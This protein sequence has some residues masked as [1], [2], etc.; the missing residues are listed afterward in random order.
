MIRERLLHQLPLGL[1]MVA[2]L[3]G[4]IAIGMVLDGSLF[5][6]TNAS[7][8]ATGEAEVRIAVTPREDGSIKVG[9]QQQGDDGTWDKVRYPDLN[10]VPAGAEPNRRLHSSVLTVSTS[11]DVYTLADSYYDYARG[12]AAQ[13]ADFSPD[14]QAW[15]LL[16]DA[17]EN[18]PGR[19]ICQG[20]AD[21]LGEEAVETIRY[22][23][24]TA[25][26]GQVI[27][28]IAGGER[29]DLLGVSKI[30]ELFGLLSALARIEGPRTSIAFPFDTI[31]PQPPS[32]A[33]YC[34]IGHGDNSF[35]N[36][37]FEAAIASAS[38]LG[39]NAEYY[40]A[41][42][43]EER[44]ADIRECV[45]NGVDSIAVTLAE[46]EHVADAIREARANGIPVVTFNS[47]A[48]AAQAAGSMLHLGLDDRKA[49]EVVGER[50]TADGVEGPV[51]CLVHE[52]QNVGL[53]ERCEGLDETYGEVETL[54][55]ADGFN[56]LSE[57]LAVGDVGAVVLLNAADSRPVAET[58]EDSGVSPTLA[59][60][61]FD[62]SV[63]V[64][65]LAD[66]ITF[67]VWDHGIL[68]GYLAVAL[69]ALADT[70]FLRPDL[71]F[72]GAQLLIEP[73]II[74]GDDMRRFGAPGG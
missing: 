13:T 51:L 70:A 3:M 25:G 31:D 1:L 9:L 16:H 40:T 21:V 33:N 45:A 65:L 39:V 58:I 56:P 7:T 18:D 52:A 15:C 27:G 41:A 23:D 60:I 44:A 30:E 29:P 37:L 72:N 69:A 62:A 59:V 48:S 8:A 74:T 73:S 38:H 36:L 47:G 71:V 11:A 61:G 17:A 5:S 50:L 26:L 63:A 55:V 4:G 2:V 67:A 66:R 6:G 49:G 19:A 68:Q 22:T 42:R 35:W 24:L 46:T 54:S 34:V 64:L 20:L 57:R 43:A 10:I 14:S 28:R 12:V 32:D 53:T